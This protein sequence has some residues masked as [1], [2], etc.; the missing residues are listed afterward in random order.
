M[1]NIYNPLNYHFIPPTPPLGRYH[2]PKFTSCKQRHLYPANLPFTINGENK[3]FYDKNRFKQYVSANPVLQKV[4]EEKPQIKEANYTHKK[5][6]SD[7]SPP[8]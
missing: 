2:V 6:A 3:I 7:K 1:T 4:L 8:A 5:Q